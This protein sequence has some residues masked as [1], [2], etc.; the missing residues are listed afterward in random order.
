MKTDIIGLA[1]IIVGYLIGSK[2]SKNTGA[3]EC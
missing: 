2:L 1:L 3:V